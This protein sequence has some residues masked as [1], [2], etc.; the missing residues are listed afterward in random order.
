MIAYDASGSRLWVIKGGAES[1]PVVSPS[2]QLVFAATSGTGVIARS[3]VDGHAVWRWNE[4]LPPNR[5][6]SIA[7]LTVS[8]SGH[9]VYVAGDSYDPN[10][11]YGYRRMLLVA[12]DAVTGVQRWARQP[13]VLGDEPASDV[14]VSSSGTR[15]AIVGSTGYDYGS[16]GLTALYRADDG[17]RYW[18]RRV[19]DSASPGTDQYSSVEKVE[20]SPSGGTVYASGY[21]YDT[22]G[23]TV[24]IDTTSGRVLWKRGLADAWHSMALAVSPDGSRLYTAWDRGVLTTVAY[25]TR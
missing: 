15:V 9:F 3:T 6:T 23:V 22:G 21:A 8:G 13:S 4:Q 19:P 20:F 25:S 7:A 17:Y 5:Q 16:L 18:L 14:A 2:G 24:A 11:Y 1:S 12:I 10:D